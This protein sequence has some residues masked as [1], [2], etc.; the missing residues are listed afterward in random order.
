MRHGEES[1][2]EIHWSGLGDLDE[3][4]R[5]GAE[6]RL[7]ALGDAHSDLI[8][9]RI[10]GHRTRHHRLGEQEV[11]ISALARGHPLV[12][13]RTRADLG[14]ALHDALDV[15]ERELQRRREKRRDL[16]RSGV[17]EPAL[18]GVVDRIFRDEGYGFILTDDG[19]RV[20]FHRNAV[21]EGLDFDRL[22]EADRV[23]LNVEAGR[24]GLQSTSVVAPP[25]GEG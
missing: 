23:A 12:A 11:R 14:L 18:L 16:S 15:F 10:S 4:E 24:E 1:A 6:R 3:S 20:Y 21:K 9:V 7:R 25:P 13:A 19:E 2:L 17:A 5:A 8:D 22:E